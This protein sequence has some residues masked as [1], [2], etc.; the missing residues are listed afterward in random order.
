MEMNVSPIPILC[1][2]I[3]NEVFEVSS[4]PRAD[5]S[6]TRTIP[7]THLILPVEVSSHSL[8]RQSSESLSSGDALLGLADPSAPLLA[9]SFSSLSVFSQPAKQRHGADPNKTVPTGQCQGNPQE[10]KEKKGGK[11][12]T[13][14]T[15]TWRVK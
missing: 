14:N 2:S 11:P 12:E 3:E 13:E 1:T 10:R 4:E 9:S 8:P 5:D 7:Y 15:L 6:S